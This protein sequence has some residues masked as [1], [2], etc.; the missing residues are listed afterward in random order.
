MRVIDEMADDNAG[1]DITVHIVGGALS[2]PEARYSDIAAFVGAD[3]LRE[4]R[5]RGTGDRYDLAYTIAQRVR[6]ANGGVAPDTVLVAN[7]ADPDKFFDALA[8]SPV[9]SANGYPIL[10]V[11]YDSVPAQTRRIVDDF[12]PSRVIIGGGPMTVSNGVRSTL[13]AERWYGSSRYSTA[14]RIAENAVTEGW[15]DPVYAG[16]AAKLPDALTGGAMVGSMRGALLVTDGRSLT[17]VTGAWLDAHGDTIDTCYVF[18]GYKSVEP[19]VLGQ[20][21]DRLR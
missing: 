16:V 8:L 2:V 10:L 18:G 17:N 1:T 19:Q 11:A 6:Q 7:G 14:T 20:I 15:L 12:A 13:G 21:E 5:L 9:T 4:D 3:R